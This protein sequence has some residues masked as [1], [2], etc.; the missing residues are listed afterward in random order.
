V[1]S[2]ALHDTHSKDLDE[3][4]AAKDFAQNPTPFANSPDVKF[5][6]HSNCSAGRCLRYT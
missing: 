1:C 5:V 3:C 6:E 4:C 2:V